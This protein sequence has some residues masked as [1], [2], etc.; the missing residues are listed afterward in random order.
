MTNFWEKGRGELKEEKKKQTRGTND[1][2]KKEKKKEKPQEEQ[3]GTGESPSKKKTKKNKSTRKIAAQQITASDLNTFTDTFLIKMQICH[4]YNMIF[5]DE[6]VNLKETSDCVKENLKKITKFLQE[7]HD[8]RAYL[9][10]EQCFGL[11]GIFL[12]DRLKTRHHITTVQ[13]TCTRAST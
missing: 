4:D 13:T 11:C 5:D 8:T 2:K 1:P 10:G 9:V 12:R 6:H 7:Q 3:K